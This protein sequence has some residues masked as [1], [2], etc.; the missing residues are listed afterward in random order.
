MVCWVQVFCNI[1][2]ILVCMVTKERHIELLKECKRMIAAELRQK[3]KK[4]VLLQTKVSFLG[5]IMDA[6]GVHIDQAKEATRNYS[7]PSSAKELRT[8]LRMASNYGKFCCV[9]AQPG[10]CLS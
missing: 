1:D 3:A 4:C 7:T 9:R 6:N 2:D 5:H 8:F 10:V